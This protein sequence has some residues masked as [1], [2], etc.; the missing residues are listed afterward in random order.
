ME[1]F[2]TEPKEIERRSFEII[3]EGLSG[4]SFPEDTRDIVKRV[5]HTTADFDYAESLVFSE[6]AV[7]RA[8]K[9][10]KEK[11]AIVTDTMMAY[12]GINKKALSVLNCSI[13]CFMGDSDVA[14]EAEERKITRAWVS[15]ERAAALDKKLIFAIG[16]AP[17]ALINIRKMVEEGRL[18]PE[19]VIAVPV[20]F[21]NV[22]EAKELIIKSDI[23]HIVSRGN[24]GGSSVAAAIMN[25]ILYKAVK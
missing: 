1:G 9:A 4:M 24:K 8:I 2:I 23:P 20:G 14:G 22:R 11:A 15:M 13:H 19:L 5:I 16:N 25:A 10:L 17:T 7:E 12:S 6:G 3:E 18:E 21:V